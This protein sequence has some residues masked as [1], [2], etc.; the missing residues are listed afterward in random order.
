MGGGMVALLVLA[1]LYSKLCGTK[2]NLQQ[3]D[4]QRQESRQRW[5]ANKDGAVM[6][7][8]FEVPPE[9]E[10]EMGAVAGICDDCNKHGHQICVIDNLGNV[11]RDLQEVALLLQGHDP[12][13][14]PLQL[15]MRAKND[16]TVTLRPGKSGM[17]TDG[18]GKVTNVTEPA[19][20]AGVQEGWKIMTINGQEFSSKLLAEMSSSSRRWPYDLKFSASD[21][22]FG[23]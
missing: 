22:Q 8:V 1:F 15:V 20:A 18:D 4:E 14:Y 10:N 21:A 12:E 17:Q 5:Q 6:T 23:A 13:A 9:T 16:R 2:K 19:K 11:K 7:K 3:V